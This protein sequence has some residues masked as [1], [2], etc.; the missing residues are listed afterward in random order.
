[1]RATVEP[2]T[3]DLRTQ[4]SAQAGVEEHPP[5][6]NR[7]VTRPAPSIIPSE[8]C[9]MASH[10]SWVSTEKNS[11][12][13]YGGLGR[14]RECLPQSKKGRNHASLPG[15][16]VPR[17]GAVCPGLLPG[18][19]SFERPPRRRYRK[20]GSDR[21]VHAPTPAYLRP[22]AETN[23]KTAEAT[24]RPAGRVSRSYNRLSVRSNNCMQQGGR[25]RRTEE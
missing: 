10:D 7:R 12:G 20:T 2:K 5:S 1:M 25:A 23:W 13:W 17:S 14:P 16:C 15:R 11:V 3:R 6:P 21:P 9:R 8:G 19:V 18:S 22:C 24:S 4:K